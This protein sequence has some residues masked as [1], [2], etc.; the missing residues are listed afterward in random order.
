MQT[1]NISVIYGEAFY[2]QSRV[3]ADGNNNYVT[4]RVKDM[5]KAYFIKTYFHCNINVSPAGV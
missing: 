3:I 2:W 5:R 4:D 1:F